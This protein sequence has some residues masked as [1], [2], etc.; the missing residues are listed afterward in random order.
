MRQPRHDPDDWLRIY[1][2][3]DCSIAA[4]LFLELGPK[5][6]HEYAD[7]GCETIEANSGHRILAPN[8]T[9]CHS[10]VAS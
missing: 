2:P 1:H 9:G 7:R 4:L 8:A 6:Y 3:G 5:D 10:I